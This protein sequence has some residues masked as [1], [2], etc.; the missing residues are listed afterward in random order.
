[1]EDDICSQLRPKAEE[2]C[3]FKVTFLN[4]DLSSTFAT[5]IHDLSSKEAI[6]KLIC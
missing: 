3:W 4:Y 6:L 1:M 2:I 5:K